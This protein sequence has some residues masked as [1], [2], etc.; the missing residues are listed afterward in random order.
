MLNI[1]I[2]VVKNVTKYIYII[3]RKYEVNRLELLLL[4]T[5]KKN[6]FLTLSVRTTEKLISLNMVKMCFCI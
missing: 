1:H 5:D 3:Q 2:N 6:V 4:N